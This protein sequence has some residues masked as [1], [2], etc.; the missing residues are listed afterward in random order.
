MQTN[1]V[2]RAAWLG[3]MLLCAAAVAEDRPPRYAEHLDL[4]Y[5]LDSAGQKRPIRTAGDWE[6]RRGHLLAHM[7]EVMGPFPAA[8]RRAPLEVN[9]EEE[10]TLDGGLLRRKLT[11]Q[12]AA[13]H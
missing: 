7:Q 2:L 11:Y 10:V 13:D 1:R 12:S 4:S 8:D 9:V 5:Y 6:I 3:T